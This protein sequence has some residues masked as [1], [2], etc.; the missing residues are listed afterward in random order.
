MIHYILDTDILTLYQEGQPQVCQN[1]A[2]HSSEEL[3]ISI[4]TVEEQLSGW[5]S[6]IRRPK[7]ING[8]RD[9]INGLL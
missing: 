9:S 3:A 4:I 1:V 8:R 2:A 6:M 7:T 5:F